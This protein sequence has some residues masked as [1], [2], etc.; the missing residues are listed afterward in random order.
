MEIFNGSPQF[1]TWDTPTPPSKFDGSR[2]I[3]PGCT[4]FGNGNDPRARF[5]SIKFVDTVGITFVY[6]PSKGLV[7]IQQ[8]RKEGPGSYVQPLLDYPADSLVCMYLHTESDIN[9]CELCIQVRDARPTLGCPRFVVSTVF[10]QKAP[11]RMARFPNKA[12]VR[13]DGCWLRQYWE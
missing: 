1:Q 6:H 7:D 10:N 9:V 11:V 8:H 5:F 13:D 3:Y 4:T 12:T 2:F